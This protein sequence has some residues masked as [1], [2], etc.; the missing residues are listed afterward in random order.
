M[1]HSAE[2]R[3]RICLS[4]EQLQELLVQ[5][6]NEQAKVVFTNGCFDL[7]HKGHV[8]YLAK[9]ADLGDKLVVA[10]NTDQSVRRLKGKARPIQDEQ[11]RLHIMA[12]LA[13]VDAVIL[14]DEETPYELIRFV[15]PDVL[16]K[17]SDYQ[18]E[19][20][21]G[22]DIV[23]AKGG[24][25]KTIDFLPGYSTSAIEQKIRDNK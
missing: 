25:V 3:K 18:P 7:L 21:V 13:C 17:G 8:D 1:S 14:F 2:I 22:Y 15:Q 24:E 19:S 16:V 12:S 20:I 11:A 23:T 10:L 6:R 5:W 4:K 9:A